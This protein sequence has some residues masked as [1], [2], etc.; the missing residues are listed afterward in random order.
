MSSGAFCFFGIMSGIIVAGVGTGVATVF[1]GIVVGRGRRDDV[2]FFF[3]AGDVFIFGA[4]QRDVF[5]VT[6]VFGFAGVTGIVLHT[7]RQVFVIAL[8]FVAAGRRVALRQPVEAAGAP[9][10][11]CCAE[12]VAGV[13]ALFGVALVFA[14][15]TLVGSGHIFGRDILGRVAGFGRAFAGG[16][17]IF[18]A[19]G[20]I[21]FDKAA[22]F[23]V[24]FADVAFIGIFAD[25]RIGVIALVGQAGIAAAVAGF[26][27]GI[28]AAGDFIKLIAGF[29]RA[30]AFGVFIL[31]TLA[32]I[33]FDVTLAELIFLAEVTGIGSLAGAGVIII[34]IQFVAVSGLITS[35]CFFNIA[36][37]ARVVA[38]TFALVAIEPLGGFTGIN[39]VVTG[40]FPRHIS[41]FL[42]GDRRARLFGAEAGCVLSR[43]ASLGVAFDITFVI[44]GTGIPF[45]R[46]FTV[47]QPG[48]ISHVGTATRYHK[49]L[50]AVVQGA[51]TSGIGIFASFGIAVIAFGR[52]TG[53]FAGETFF[54]AGEIAAFLFFHVIADAVGTEA[55]GVFAAGAGFGS[56]FGVAAKF[57]NALVAFEC[58]GAGAKRAVIAAAVVAAG[59]RIASGGT[60]VFAIMGRVLFGTFGFFGII[61]VFRVAGIGAGI[62]VFVAGFVVGRGRRGNVAFFAWAGNVF[63]GRTLFG[64]TFDITAV[65]SFA[66]IA[67]VVFFAGFLI[68][69]KILRGVAFGRLVA[70]G[71]R[72]GGANVLRL[73]EIAGIHVFIIA[74][75]GV[76]SIGAGVAL[77]VARPAAA[78]GRRGD[79]AGLG[80]HSVYCCSGSDGQFN[81]SPRE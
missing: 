15:V 42:F 52:D 69:I 75:G 10:V 27:A 43:R 24:G 55:G 34:I 11:V 6:A 81:G 18:R 29:F 35:G 56:A 13:I 73:G 40:I 46:I 1:P 12:F 20:G 33:A 14:S 32:G 5:D 8:L 47:L 57:F 76:A 53:V 16:I 7:Q 39:A 68:V 25:A 37:F 58:A 54:L 65:L 36:G 60:A 31:R 28:I 44:E 23:G 3:R 49:T 79:I 66:G 19:G 4:L 50:R 61:L 80:G 17:F 77:F 41:A 30:A 51:G 64:R 70:A 71:S 74:A 78:W 63:A 72:V 67:V 9:F 22:G 45:E 38:G 2:A 26:F 62:A 59:R 48:V 21:G